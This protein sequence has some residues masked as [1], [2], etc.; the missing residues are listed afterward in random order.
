MANKINW[1]VDEFEAPKG[2]AISGTGLAGVKI[3]FRL[4]VQ[5]A[6]GGST[7]SIGAKFTGQMIVGPL[8]AAVEREGQKA[9]D[10]SLANLAAIAG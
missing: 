3:S 2:P 1:T 5:P 6:D 9:I 4:G 10:Q 8:G 7:V